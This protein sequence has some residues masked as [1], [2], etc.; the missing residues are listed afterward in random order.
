M[1][2][3]KVKK[4]TKPVEKKEKEV[5]ITTSSD[6]QILRLTCELKEQAKDIYEL[7]QRID[8]IVDAHEKCKS[9][10]KL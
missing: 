8:R 4:E 1:A 9:L 10:R 2:K 6:T 3:K 5:A 7:N